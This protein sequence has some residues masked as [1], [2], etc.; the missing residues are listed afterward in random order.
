MAVIRWFFILLLPLSVSATNYYVSAGSGSDSNDGLS[1][2]TPYKHISMVCALSPGDTAFLAGSFPPESTYYESWTGYQTLAPQT[3]GSS[4]SPI[5]YKNWPDSGRPK[6]V[7]HINTSCDISQFHV[8]AFISGVNYIT[9]DSIEFY[10][11]YRGIWLRGGSENITIKHCYS[12]H[13]TGGANNNTGN[14]YI[15]SACRNVTIEYNELAHAMYGGLDCSTP[16]QE[17][18]WNTGGIYA[19]N[20]GWDTSAAGTYEWQEQYHSSRFIIQNNTI[21]DQGGCGIR[22]KRNT[23]S[24]VVRNNT[25]YNCGAAGIVISN[26]SDFYIYYYGNVLYGCDDHAFSASGRNDWKYIDDSAVYVFNNTVY[27]GAKGL[28]IYGEPTWSVFYFWN[29]IYSDCGVAITSAQSASDLS[30]TDTFYFDYNCYSATS[31]W[32]FPDGSTYSTLSAWQGATPAY[33]Y[34]NDLNSIT[35]YPIFTDSAGRDFSLQTGSP[36]LTTYKDTT[37]TIGWTGEEIT[38]DGMGA[39]NVYTD[40]VAR[41][42]TVSQPVE[43]TPAQK[44]VRATGKVPLSGVTIQ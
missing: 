14:I 42:S 37:F 29:N 17:G 12:H 1:T 34:G 25:I 3:S 39:Y 18:G 11:G 20:E 30:S 16:Y 41:D 35:S 15:G 2:S 7:G 5:V 8:T 13:S 38:V 23:D 27:D 32:E 40:G 6:I 10:Y 44:K 26:S 43:S 24:T 21:H 19:E 9:L 4:G 22:L 33:L 31:S 36:C 28:G